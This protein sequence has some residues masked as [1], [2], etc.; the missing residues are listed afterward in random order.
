M[1]A[2][3]LMIQIHLF[4]IGTSSSSPVSGRGNGLESS[5]FLE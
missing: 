2:A 4:C 5:V 1:R 3:L